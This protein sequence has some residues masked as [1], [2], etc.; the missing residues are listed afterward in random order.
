[1]AGDETEPTNLDSQ[2]SLGASSALGY[3]AITFLLSRPQVSD[4]IQRWMD[5]NTR[6]LLPFADESSSVILGVMIN[7][8]PSVVAT[9][10]RR[11]EHKALA[12]GVNAL[13]LG[14]ATMT[15]FYVESLTQPNP[16]MYREIAFS[17]AGAVLMQLSDFVTH[18][19]DRG[20]MADS[21]VSS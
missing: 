14:L 5:L 4:L 8:L 16:E 20:V 11:R 7:A 21:D 1:M 10:L 18:M 15:S 19:I 17:F 13:G 6:E 9:Q 12:I 2:I 3:A